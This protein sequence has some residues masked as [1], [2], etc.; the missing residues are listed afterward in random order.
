MRV[1]RNS[2]YMTVTL[3]IISFA[4]CLLLHYEYSSNEAEFWCNVTLGVF[5]GALL[6]LITSIIG[7]R[8]ER[9]KVLENF[10]Y[11]TKRIL[12]QLN[13]YQ[14]NMSLEKKIDF[15]LHYSD[16]DKIEWDSCLGEISFLIDFKR[17]NFMYIY[18]SLYKPLYELDVAIQ[19]HYWHFLWHKD[20]SG[21]SDRAMQDFVV[22]IEE[23]ILQKEKQQVPAK[24]DKNGVAISYTEREVIFNRIVNDL[25][26][27]LYGKYYL[28]TYG[29]KD[30]CKRK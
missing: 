4:I 22:E 25:L 21:K 9:R 30:N 10:S 13:K 27:E 8:V 28:L 23:L 20:G 16:F 14:N 1:Y 18:N 2:I 7:Y 5:S 29:K 19:K 3:S 24:V 15:F 11:Y 12:N 17:K 6:T 26:N